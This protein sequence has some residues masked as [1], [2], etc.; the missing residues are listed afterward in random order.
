MLMKTQAQINKRLDDYV[1]GIVDSPYRVKKW[2]SYDYRFG[3]MEPGAIDVDK[4]FHAQCILNGA[5]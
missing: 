4:S 3:A 5:L 2:T 1:K